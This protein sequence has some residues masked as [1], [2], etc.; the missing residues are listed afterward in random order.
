RGSQ[1]EIQLVHLAF[2][3]GECEFEKRSTVVSHRIS[4]L[5]TM[6]PG[7]HTN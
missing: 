1:S 6:R 5:K 7:E 4:N 2:S 3:P